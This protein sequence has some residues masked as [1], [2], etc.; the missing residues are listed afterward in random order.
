MDCNLEG[1]LKKCHLP[2]RKGL[3]PVFEAIV[4]S[5]HAI[6]DAKTSNG[7]I[8]IHIERDTSQAQLDGIDGSRPIKSFVITDNGIGFT[9][10]NYK[11]FETYD[12]TY[13]ISRGGKGVGRLLWLV[14]FDSVSVDSI[15][16]QVFGQP[17]ILS[18]VP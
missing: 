11:S 18:R 4:N 1:R 2:L 8:N 5:I 13:K 10:E 15:F 9:D 16:M 7:S 3:W 12:S 17:L 14:A 6:E